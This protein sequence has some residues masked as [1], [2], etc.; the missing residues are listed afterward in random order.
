MSLTVWPSKFSLKHTLTLKRDSRV[1]AI[2]NT[3]GDCPRELLENDWRGSNRTSE[4]KKKSPEF[5]VTS[6]FSIYFACLE[7]LLYWEWCAFYW[8][9][10]SQFLGWRILGDF[11]GKMW[12][13]DMESAAYFEGMEGE[14]KREKERASE[15]TELRR[16]HAESQNNPH[17]IVWTRKNTAELPS[18]LI[19]CQRQ[20][21]WI[22]THILKPGFLS[23]QCL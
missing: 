5:I 7:A 12:G 19:T 18:R 15:A 21:H 20:G 16:L 6:F 3:C 1:E 10:L 13:C 22:F 11:R 8:D 4:R 23:L 14:R 17:K 2:T 9:H